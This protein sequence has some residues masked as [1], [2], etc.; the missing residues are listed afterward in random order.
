MT[1]DRDFEK[2]YKLL[3][4]KHEKFLLLVHKMRDQQKRYF[5]HRNSLALADAKK[6]EKQV[7]SL[8]IKEKEELDI[9]QGELFR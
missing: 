7:D 6:L 8:T 1:E 5:K 4:N 9:K 3:A 2:E